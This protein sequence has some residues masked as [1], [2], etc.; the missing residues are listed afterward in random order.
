VSAVGVRLSVIQ[1]DTLCVYVA[2]YA[3]CWFY[4]VVEAFQNLIRDE[5]YGAYMEH[6]ATQ[7]MQ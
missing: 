7:V 6:K 5:L 2:S 1:M 4:V 3:N